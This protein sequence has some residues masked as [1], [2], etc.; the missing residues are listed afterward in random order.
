MSEEHLVK[1]ANDIGAFFRAEPDREE[2]LG[3]IVNHIVKFW[4]HRMREKLIAV[5]H[6]GRSTEFD[7]LTLE[8]VR[9]LAAAAGEAKRPA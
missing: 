8:A 1:M 2:A 6:E 3:G 7:E 4:T 9:R 5:L